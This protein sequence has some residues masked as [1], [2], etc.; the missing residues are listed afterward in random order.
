MICNLVFPVLFTCQLENLISA[1]DF[2]FCFIYN[3]EIDH[4]WPVDFFSKANTEF[5]KMD[6]LCLKLLK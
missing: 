4:T 1:P 6:V 3:E 5:W 2:F